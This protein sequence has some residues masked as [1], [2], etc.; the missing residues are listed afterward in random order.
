MRQA[1]V[2]EAPDP[3]TGRAVVDL[4][5]QETP[6]QVGSDLRGVQVGDRVTVTHQ[7]GAW[8]IVAAR[9]WHVPP[10]VQSTGA[11][12]VDSF[13]GTSACA[14]A[15]RTYDRLNEMIPRLDALFQAVYDQRIVREP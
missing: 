4:A 10:S 7:G 2:R 6:V 15:T 9:G 13:G 3:D 8:W 11:T 14:R 1:V 5:G 12:L